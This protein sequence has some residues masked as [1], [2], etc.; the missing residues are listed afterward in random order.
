MFAK[1][2]YQ[3]TCSADFARE[4]EAVNH[5]WKYHASVKEKTNLELLYQRVEILI[6]SLNRPFSWSEH[7]YSC[8]A[9]RGALRKAS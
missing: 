2:F 4:E 1:D 9:L 5:V 8:S 3:C 7:L 6:S